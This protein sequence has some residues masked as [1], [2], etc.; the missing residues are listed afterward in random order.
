MGRGWPKLSLGAAI[1]GAILGL[2]RPAGATD[3]YVDDD[4]AGDPC[5][6]GTIKYPLDRIQGAINAAANGDTVIVLEGVYYENIH[7]M[8]INLV[9]TSTDPEDWSVVAGTVIDG[10]GRD[11]TVRFSG[12]ESAVS[13]LRGFTITGGTKIGYGGGIFGNRTLAAISQCI[14]ENNSNAPDGK[15]ETK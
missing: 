2:V 13:E 15:S 4:A 5:Q 8:G 1:I 9:L 14:I 6:I 3:W 12:S 10:R 11:T 7:L